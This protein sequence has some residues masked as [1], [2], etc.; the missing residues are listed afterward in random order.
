MLTTGGFVKKFLITFAVVGMLCAAVSAQAPASPVSI[1]VG[2]GLSMPM[3]PDGFKDYWKMGF[4]GMV[5]AGYGLSPAFQIVA[6]GEYHMLPLDVD[7]V[8]GGDLGFLMF[9][10]DG[11]FAIGLPA[12]PIKPFVLGGLGMANISASDITKGEYTVLFGDVTKFYFNVGAG[13]EFKAGPKMS[14]FAQARYVDVMTEGD[15]LAFI[16]FTVGLKFF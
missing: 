10:V 6:K 9:G 7:S 8:E 13:V 11:R 15:A 3:A 14:L 16:P 5:G 4:N 2:G 12:A 1:Y